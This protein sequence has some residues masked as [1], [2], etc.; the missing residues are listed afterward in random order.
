M[1]LGNAME[2]VRHAVDCFELGCEATWH[3]G[4]PAMPERTNV[5]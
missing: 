2:P 3:D 5:V 4:E 1:S